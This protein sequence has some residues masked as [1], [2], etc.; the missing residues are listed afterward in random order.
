MT[1]LAPEAESAIGLTRGQKA[2]AGLGAVPTAKTQHPYIVGT[3]LVLVGGF[4]L[5]G[6][7]TGTLPSMLAALFAPNALIVSAD[8]SAVAPDYHGP[9]ILAPVNPLT[10]S[11]TLGTPLTVGTVK[12]LKNWLITNPSNWLNNL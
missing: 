6:S 5:I 8:G 12:D 11:P 1:M 7:I 9:A 4:G 10:S 3:V 2:A